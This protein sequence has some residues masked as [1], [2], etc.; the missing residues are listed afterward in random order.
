MRAAL[1]S[2]AART[3]YLRELA[4][5]GV[6]LVAAVSACLAAAALADS[7]AMAVNEARS[8][9]QM[10]ADALAQRIAGTFAD[11]GTVRAQRTVAALIAQ[12][13]D[14]WPELQGVGVTLPG[15]R[16]V[17]Q[18]A[19]ASGTLPPRTPH[20]EARFGAPGSRVGVVS[21]IWSP[22]SFF[23]L[24]ASWA[25]PLAAALAVIAL[26]SG[27]ALRRA[28]SRGPG[29]RDL[30]VETAS[31]QI[32]R[33]NYQW[34]LLSEP[35]RRGHDL[36]ASAL[37]AD[38][39]HVNELHRQI[40]RLGNSLRQTEPD[41]LR[42]ADLDAILQ[43]ATS[44]ELFIG[45]GPVA[46]VDGG[47]E[48]ANGPWHGSWLWRLPAALLLA[49]GVGLPWALASGVLDASHGKL[50]YPLALTAMALGGACAFVCSWGGWRLRALQW[51][52]RQPR[53]VTDAA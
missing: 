46:G 37:A 43:E 19:A 33:G 20:V 44:N 45:D 35:R 36:R 51:R 3:R 23:S 24:M 25:P 42:R 40:S 38:L 52:A 39:R 26:A 12:R 50:A 21:V 6:W 1:A 22:P 32:L 34:R 4:I 9:A 31:R 2:R 29:Q 7:H 15:Q 17:W 8:R 48:P 53:R 16:P 10:H 5:A 30:V 14:Q 27:W 41:C 28:W 13:L 47:A 18:Y 49:V 11:S